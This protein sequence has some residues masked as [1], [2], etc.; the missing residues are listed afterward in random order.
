MTDFITTTMAVITNNKG[1]LI[2]NMTAGT[3]FSCDGWIQGDR[4]NIGISRWIPVG[5]YMLVGI[6]PPVDPPPVE[7]PVDPPLATNGELTNIRHSVDGGITWNVGKFYEE[8]T[9]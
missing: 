7:P 4:L 5:T 9:I 6:I 1:G 3:A 8:V 2:G